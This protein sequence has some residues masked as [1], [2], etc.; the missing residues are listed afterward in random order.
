MEKEKG[1]VII[2]AMTE[3]YS[4]CVFEISMDLNSAAEKRGRNGRGSDN[5]MRISKK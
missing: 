5:W 4:Y 2:A 1:K 3:I